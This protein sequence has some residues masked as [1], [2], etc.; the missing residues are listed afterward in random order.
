MRKYYY[1]KKSRLIYFP[2]DGYWQLLHANG[3]SEASVSYRG[4]S[5]NEIPNHFEELTFDHLTEKLLPN[6][7]VNYELDKLKLILLWSGV[8]V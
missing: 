2:K 4:Y 5:T 1:D 7:A 8:V 3:N 6:Y